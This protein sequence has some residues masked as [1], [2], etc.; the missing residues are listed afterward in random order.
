MNPYHDKISNVIGEQISTSLL[1]E[2]TLQR[3]PVALSL[4]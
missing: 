1:T 4:G 2:T 3:V